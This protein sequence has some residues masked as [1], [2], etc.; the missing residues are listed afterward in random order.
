[1]KQYKEEILPKAE[2]YH[3]TKLVQA[4]VYHGWKVISLD[5]LISIILYTDYSQHSSHFTAT[6]RKNN[7]FEPIQSIKR[8]HSNYYWASKILRETVYKYGKD[9][10]F[11]D[12]LLGPFYCGMSSVMTMPQFTISLY[13]PTS[14]SCHIEV[15]MKFSGTTGII[16]EF[17]NKGG[18][19]RIVKGLDVSWLSRY[20]EE[21]E[22]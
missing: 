16:V 8:R 7:T 21:D 1:M 11:G 22:V 18:D 15:A 14:T 12:G 13:S 3:K 6:F 20:K 9:Y 19:A 2:E 10:D 5:N 17:N 4:M